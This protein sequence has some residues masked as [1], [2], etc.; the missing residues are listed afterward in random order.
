MPRF[1]FDYL[2]QGQHIETDH[3]GT[4][5]PDLAAARAE[6]TEAA[7][8][9]IMDNTSAEGAELELSVRDGT[10]GPIF[11]VNASIKI[12]PRSA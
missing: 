5:L 4:V 8:E 2:V 9:W 11:V 7:A 3:V 10:P 12:V 1:Y 6:A